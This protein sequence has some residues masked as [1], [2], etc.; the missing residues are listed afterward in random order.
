[1]FTPTAFYQAP[2]ASVYDDI[3]ALFDAS[4]AGAGAATWTA[5]SSSLGTAPSVTRTDTGVSY[6]S[7]GS[8]SHYLFGSS[9]YMTGSIAP[10]GASGTGWTFNMWVMP[11]TFASAPVGQAL[12]W[13]DC[14]GGGGSGTTTDFGAQTGNNRMSWA[15]YAANA[16]TSIGGGTTSSTYSSPN[17]NWYMNTI[18]WNGVDA[19]CYVNN[20][21]QVTW[22]T[23]LQ[24][25][26]FP[27]FHNPVLKVGTLNKS[28]TTLYLNGGKVA[29]MEIW[30]RGLASTE[31]TEVWNTNRTRFGY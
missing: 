8:A 9:D 1:M 2:S 18:V 13:I 14:G 17:T 23:T 12:Y 7:S 24:P 26:T 4:G 15:Y 29:M 31:L 21:L 25:A 5:D 27:N 16:D 6:V 28:A 11:T 20:G 10:L 22:D 3:L 19:K 30:N